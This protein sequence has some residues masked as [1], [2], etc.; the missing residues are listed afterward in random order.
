M[1]K[2]HGKMVDHRASLYYTVKTPIFSTSCEI[3][4]L[5]ITCVMK[6]MNLFFYWHVI[7]KRLTI[8]FQ[9]RRACCRS[10]TTRCHCDTGTMYRHVLTWERRSSCHVKY[11]TPASNLATTRT[12]TASCSSTKNCKLTTV[13]SSF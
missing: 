2:T 6:S 13:L 12:S 3:Y 4:Y 9:K 5:N 8:L 7:I 11:R 1:F 10:R